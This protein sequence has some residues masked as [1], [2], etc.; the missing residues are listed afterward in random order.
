M[1]FASEAGLDDCVEAAPMSP[2]GFRLLA[3]QEEGQAEPARHRAWCLLASLSGQGDVE[4]RAPVPLD[5]DFIH[6][7]ANP[8]DASS[9]AF[10][11][12]MTLL[13]HTG[14]L[15]GTPD[16]GSQPTLFDEGV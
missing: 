1:A 9:M 15:P 7:M 10:W 2:T 4:A 3:G 14:G 6:W 13:R 5:Q 16:S 11:E 12:V 8:A